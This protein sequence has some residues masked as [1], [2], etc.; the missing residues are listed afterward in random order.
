MNDNF[1]KQILNESHLGY[2]FHKI[3]LDDN[4]KPIDYEFIEVNT[5]F[6][7]LTG[8]KRSDV[9]GKKITEVLPDIKKSEFNW[10]E[11][12]GNVAINGGSEELE[13]FSEP[14][15][16]WYKVK[17]YSPEKGSFITTFIDIT[18]ERKKINDLYKLSSMSEELLEG[19]KEEN[20]YQIITD[21]LLKLA[22]AKF[23]IFN[24]YEEDGKY[25]TTK[26]IAGDR[27]IANKAM[28]I[29]G[30]KVDKKKWP[31]DTVRA[32]KIKEKMVTH[33]PTL[34][35]LAGD[36][37]PK[38]LCDLLTKS[39]GFG[40]IVVVKIMKNNLM[41]GDFTI[42]MAKGK[43]FDKDS[44]V[45]IYATQVGLALISMREEA[46]ISKSEELFKTTLLSVGDGVISVDA[47]GKVLILNKVAQELTGWNH[48]EAL[49]KSIQ[50]IFHIIDATTRERSDNPVQKVILTGDTLEQTNQNILI[51]K[52]GIERPI[53]DS[54]A[55]IKDEQDNIT[56]VV[57]VF[58]DYTE[59]KKRLDEII[60][61]SFHDNLTGLYNQSFFEAEMERIDTKRN[62]PF[63]VI[64]GDVNGLKLVN[65]TFGHA[66]GD[67]LLIKV[68]EIMKISCR[69]DDII[70][71]VGGDEFIILL[72]KTD[73]IQAGKLIDRILGLMKNEKIKDIDVSVSFG[74]ATKTD[75]EQTKGFIT[76]KAE[77]S[78]YTNKLIEGQE[79]R[80]R[81]IDNIILAINRKSPWEEAHSKRVS[82]LCVAVGKELKF[83]KK[84][85]EILKTFGLLHD[86]GKIA[87]AN[88]ILNKPGRLTESE[89]YEIKRHPEIGF[90]ILSTVKDMSLIANY[91]LSHHERWDGKG[92]PKG[93]SKE[94]VPLVSR[95]CNIADAYDAMTSERSY[96]PAMS[97]EYAI[98][99]LQKNA[100]TQF[101]PVLVE[102]FLNKVLPK[103]NLNEIR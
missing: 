85:L 19:L 64:M 90:R 14:L 62:L 94:D 24:L 1:Y 68:A 30:M 42:I 3:I 69:E 5:A 73:S 7:N 47:K 74:W 58:R 81:V 40:E 71:R 51:S 89:F 59:K 92:Y 102:L 37:I 76:K 96:R 6:E 53:E 50:E 86:I 12:Y 39:F 78:M 61:L 36:V 26:V 52:D 79:F 33:F 49:G 82:E 95:I 48:E 67:E 21:N 41:L 43:K 22:E 72:P 9:L 101:D 8:L 70:A 17:V 63:T 91:V 38:A 100:G 2:A 31:H 87:I 23:A 16:R 54:T 11:F 27:G 56:G 25:Y 88:D 66:L 57:L 77:D 83:D 46:I 75:M 45:E 93:L 29:M 80:S 60:Y 44:I 55:P 10:I 34:K 32:E 18:N 103:F 20:N 84:E 65:D 13:Q 28:N 35:E 4:N 99:E 97:N 15:K 98:E